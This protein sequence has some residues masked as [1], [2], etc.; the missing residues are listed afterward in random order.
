MARHR[1]PDTQ[2]E[3]SHASSKEQWERQQT[4]PELSREQP[5]SS[6]SCQGLIR[7]LCS[8]SHLNMQE[9]LQS[10]RIPSRHHCKLHPGAVS[11]CKCSRTHHC[12]P[13]A[14]HLSHPA[15]RGFLSTEVCSWFWIPTSL[16]WACALLTTSVC[17]NKAKCIKEIRGFSIYKLY[18]VD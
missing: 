8:C 15:P 12:F 3:R 9:P 18:L 14:F 16:P 13:F 7:L 5:G 1:K 2:Q 4:K 6:G 11:K 17:R 10:V